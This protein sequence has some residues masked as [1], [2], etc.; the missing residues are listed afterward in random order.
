[1]NYAASAPV[2]TFIVDSIDHGAMAQSGAGL[3]SALKNLDTAVRT[4]AATTGID[5]AA[6]V[7]ATGLTA[8]A[9]R[10]AAAAG[11]QAAMMGMIG[12]IGGGLVTGLGSLGGGAGGLGLPGLSPTAHKDMTTPD[13]GSFGGWGGAGN[14]QAGGGFG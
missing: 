4:N 5:A 9:K 10:A 1:M 12:K 6:G 7:T 2:S 13:I 11:E 8:A 14:F 3:V